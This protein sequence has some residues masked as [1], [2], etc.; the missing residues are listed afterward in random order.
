[1]R[2]QW[3]VVVEGCE[4]VKRKSKRRKKGKKQ[5]KLKRRKEN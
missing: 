1:M 4:E 2:I 3:I 5:R